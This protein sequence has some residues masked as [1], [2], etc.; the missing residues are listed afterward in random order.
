MAREPIAQSALDDHQQ[1]TLELV[2]RASLRA[3]FNRL[4]EQR[5]IPLRVYHLEMTAE[6]MP[7]RKPGDN[8]MPPPGGCY[9]CSN[10]ACYCC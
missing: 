3:D 2:S 5:G 9:C 10:G 7:E 4:L 8:L 6:P 1:K